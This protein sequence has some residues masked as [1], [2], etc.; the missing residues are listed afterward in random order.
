MTRAEIARSIP[1]SAPQITDLAKGKR[2][3]SLDYKIADKL[4]ELHKQRCGVKPQEA[5]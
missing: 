1:C 4:R 3:K 5:A 2:G